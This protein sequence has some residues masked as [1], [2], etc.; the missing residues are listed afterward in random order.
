MAKSGCGMVPDKQMKHRHPNYLTSAQNH[1]SFSFD[2]NTYT[3]SDI[4][5]WKLNYFKCSGCVLNLDFCCSAFWGRSLT[6]THVGEIFTLLPTQEILGN[7]TSYV[8]LSL[9][10][11]TKQTGNHFPYVLI[12]YTFTWNIAYST[13]NYNSSRFNPIPLHKEWAVQWQRQ[14]YQLPYKQHGCFRSS[15]GTEWLWHGKKQMKHRVMW[16]I[17]LLPKTTALFPL[18]SIPIHKKLRSSVELPFHIYL[19]EAK[20]TGHWVMIISEKIIESSKN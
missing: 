15:N 19:A 10:L 9:F 14:E 11:R 16:T 5:N 4:H 12:V 7:V 8:L 13:V 17:L 2:F 20:A 18:I 1:R 3:T 6:L